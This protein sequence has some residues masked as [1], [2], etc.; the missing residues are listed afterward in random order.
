MSSTVTTVHVILNAHLD[1]AWLWSWPAG[2]DALLAT[3]ENACDRLDAHPDIHFS[4]G[5][6][7][8]YAQIE[9][10]APDLFA[11]ICPHVEDGRW[12]IVGGWWIQ[13]DC[14]GPSGFALTKQIECGKR[15][16]LE[17]FGVFPRTAY[18][19]DSFG[20][21]ASLPDL[22]HA[23][24][25]DRY[26]M[27][28]P[29]EDELSLPSRLFRWRGREGGAEV[30]TFRIAGTYACRELT[31]EHVEKAVTG[32]PE[33][34]AHT[35][36][37]VGLGDHG[38][39]P[40]ERQ[41]AW[42]QEHSEVLPGCRLEFSWPERFFDAVWN[43]RD[44]LPLVTGELQMHAIGCFTAHHTIKA[45]V[46]RAEHRLAQAELLRD[47]SPQVDTE[48]DRRL[49]TGWERVCFAHFHD[50]YGGTC[51]PSSDEP[52]LAQLGESY[53][54]GDEQLQLGFRRL[55]RTLPPCS[56]QRIVLFNAASIP[57]DGYVEHEAW[58]EHEPFR[59]S[60]WL[61]EA[62]G[63]AVPFQL[64][65][66]EALVRYDESWFVRMLLPIRLGPGELRGL[67]L[68]P[69]S[70]SAHRDSQDRA[71]V[72]VR[73]DGIHS[74]AGPAVLL[75]GDGGLRLEDDLLLP[76]PRF[77]LL[78]DTSDTWSHGINR[79][80]GVSAGSA[81]WNT[82]EIVYRG[83]LMAS[84]TQTGRVGASELLAEYRVYAGAR[85]VD[86]RLRVHWLERHRV[87]K[88]SL[89]APEAI[90]SR[91]DGIPGGG[92]RRPID[93]REAPVQDWTLLE[94]PENRLGIV[95][96]HVGALDA[97]SDAVRLTLLRSP[98]RAHHDPHPPSGIRGVYSDH[99]V[100]EFSFRFIGG[101][102]L[103]E[104][105]LAAHASMMHRPPLTAD[106]TRGMPLI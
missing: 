84:A 58:F 62:G 63:I 49:A 45:A 55:L 44:R 69:R 83:P 73:D 15:Y 106:L 32:L 72:A 65:E 102:G 101:A 30:V 99:G 105:E 53:S 54:I 34:V 61:H 37:F 71:H 7:W 21:A 28:R 51:V 98:L 89:K 22:M 5:E 14:N 64:L 23:A 31:V 97:S 70:G 66:P 90:R 94:L 87:L 33:G 2:L 42:I 13:P 35:M 74:G 46:R 4:K 16:F 3:C 86:L 76:L 1:P 29:Q 59:S 85:Y 50:I 91:V 38:G 47:A 75:A 8:G 9:R 96:P 68:E 88:M 77:D 52:L 19:V 40:T 10:V 79:Y 67:V 57:F 103:T 18:N 26:V 104:V 24:G 25:Q 39:G 81:S 95:L 82:P 36:C 100:H 12:H 80:V 43:Q 6:A 17:R 48:A 92:L 56:H 78:E 60:W 41:I 27:M 93:S 20:H 11:R